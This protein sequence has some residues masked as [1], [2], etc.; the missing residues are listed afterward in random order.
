MEVKNL[1]DQ[2]SLPWRAG[3]EPW[4]HSDYRVRFA[5]LFL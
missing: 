4:H 5:S 3:N 2:H 1:K